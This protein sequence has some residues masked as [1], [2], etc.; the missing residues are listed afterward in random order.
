VVGL[1]LVTLLQI[2]FVGTNSVGITS[3]RIDSVG[4][5]WC[6]QVFFQFVV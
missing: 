2:S 1:G 5:V 3:V 4:I 6:T